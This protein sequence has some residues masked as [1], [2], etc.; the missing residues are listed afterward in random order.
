VI[1]V[2]GI[3]IAVGMPDSNPTLHDQLLSTGQ[4]VSADMAYGWSLA[5]TNNS[6]YRFTFDTTRNRYV[7]EHCGTDS[8][9]NNL[10]KLPFDNSADLATQR[11]VDLDDLPHVGPAV[12]LL[13][14]GTYTSSTATKAT[15]LEFGPLGELASGCQTVIWLAAGSGEGRRYLPLLINPVTG[16]TTVGNYTGSGPPSSL[17]NN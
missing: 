9:L 13:A 12:N 5:V 10:P 2:V 4:I 16:L 7:L 14:V 3:L 15:S 11:V 8:T 17:L 1:A 6:S